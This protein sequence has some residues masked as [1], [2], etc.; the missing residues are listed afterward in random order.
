MCQVCQVRDA[1]EIYVYGCHYQYSCTPPS[2]L[3]TSRAPTCATGGQDVERGRYRRSE[4]LALYRSLSGSGE[5]DRIQPLFLSGSACHTKPCT[6]WKCVKPQTSTI[7]ANDWTGPWKPP[8]RSYSSSYHV[9]NLVP[10]FQHTS[11]CNAALTFSGSST[12]D[13][14]AWPRCSTSRVQRLA[15]FFV[16]PPYFPSAVCTLHH[17]PATSGPCNVAETEYSYSYSHQHRSPS[18]LATSSLLTLTRLRSSFS[19][20][21]PNFFNLRP[22]STR[23]IRSLPL[24]L[25]LRSYDDCPSRTPACRSRRSAFL[26]AGCC[27]YPLAVTSTL[28]KPRG[29]LST[30]LLSSSR[31]L[32][33][34]LHPHLRSSS[35]AALASATVGVCVSKVSTTLRSI[36]RSVD[37]CRR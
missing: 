7:T 14:L 25:P 8:S 3:E 29:Q 15:R 10:S 6:S 9:A 18:R 17:C 24:T 19:S 33:L 26:V 13:R 22:L 28:A 2:S 35:I 12:L 11:P 32:H 23:P 5:C 36:H 27:S 30:L 4:V 31:R 16:V 37:A 34:H 21:H 20:F 1:V